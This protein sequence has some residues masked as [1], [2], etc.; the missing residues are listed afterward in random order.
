MKDWEAYDSIDPI[1]EWRHDYRMAELIST[2][3]DFVYA[4]YHKK[5]TEPRKTNWTE[6]MPAW[7]GLKIPKINT[8]QKK[9]TVEEMKSMLQ[10]FAKQ[11]NARMDKLDALDKLGRKL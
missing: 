4:L 11:Q 5:G 8:G 10:F 2:I 9:Q 7:C 3:S 6:F 1:G